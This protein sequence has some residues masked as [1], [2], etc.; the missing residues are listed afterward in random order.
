MSYQRRGL[1]PTMRM[2]PAE[3]RYAFDF[4]REGRKN[5]GLRAG[6]RHVTK[7]QTPPAQKQA[8]RVIDEPSPQ[9]DVPRL[10]NKE[11]FVK[12]S[13]SGEPT[14]SFSPVLAQS[15]VS[16]NGEGGGGT[17]LEELGAEI[18]I[19]KDALTDKNARFRDL[20][21]NLE[22][23]KFRETVRG[24]IL[25]RDI[26]DDR[27][28]TEIFEG[29][30][31]ALISKL[32]SEEDFVAAQREAISKIRDKIAE[33]QQG[34]PGNNRILASQSGLLTYLDEVLCERTLKCSEYLIQKAET[35]TQFE[36]APLVNPLGK[37]LVAIDLN[38]V[39]NQKAGL[40]ERFCG[41]LK[42]LFGSKSKEG[43]LP[44]NIYNNKPVTPSVSVNAPSLDAAA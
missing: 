32:Q 38:P 13:R 29:Y 25:A 14:K 31:N 39:F 42:S 12:F 28:D 30:R 18:Q 22:S 11:K 35:L 23:G 27:T 5:H 1:P 26:E 37:P 17:R 6:S 4:V 19:V 7:I 36:K 8:V 20:K 9:E 15:A 41:W 43:I 44:Q 2:S 40:A 10:S 21:A 33:L 34:I 3:E 16:H 24:M